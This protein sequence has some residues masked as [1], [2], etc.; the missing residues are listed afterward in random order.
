MKKHA[1]LIIAHNQF[2]TLE[3]LIEL[4]DDER[5][6][7]Y[8]HIDKKVSHFDFKTVE[9]IAKKSTVY[10]VP[11]IK[12]SWG[13][14][15]QIECELI[16]L[17]MAAKSQYAYYHLLSG[18]DLPLKTQDEI[19]RFF[20]HY[21][22]LEFIHYA[23]DEITDL[24]PRIS[25]YHFLQEHLNKAKAKPIKYG[26]NGVNKLLLMSQ[27]MIGINRLKQNQYKIKYGA[28]WFSI[29]HGLAEEVLNR[30]EWIK[31]TFSHSSC[32]DEMFL[33]TLVYN[34]PYS[35]KLSIHKYGLDTLN[36][37]RK[38]DWERGNPYVWKKDDFNELI[39]SHYL[40][41]RKF[42]NEQD[43]AIIERL[44]QFIKKQ[45]IKPSS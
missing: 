27:K 38:I 21:D 25:S 41:A 15:S 22:G 44:Y 32:S 33:Q 34:S 39:T 2:A 37:M 7:I 13:G 14:Y 26:L 6:D 23:D 10:F 29:T 8:I 3:K 36:C 5:N 31:K 11:R 30:R 20:A 40:F 9:R 43:E 18:V 1:Y 42:D 28:Q 19:H 12:V 24:L 4:L 35:H 45:Q 16:L 17:E